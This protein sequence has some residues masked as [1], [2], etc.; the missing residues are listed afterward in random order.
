MSLNIT[1]NW[2]VGDELQWEWDNLGN[3]FGRFYD[4]HFPFSAIVL[5]SVMVHSARSSH[6]P[7]SSRQSHRVLSSTAAD[8]KK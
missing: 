6:P 1:S 3:L 8:E 5:S 7:F 2:T 4:I